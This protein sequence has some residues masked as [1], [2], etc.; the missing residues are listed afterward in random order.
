M[1]GEQE[2]TVLEVKPFGLHGM[3]YF[4]VTMRFPD[5][6][7]EQARLGPE[8]VLTISSPGERVLPRRDR[9]TM[10]GLSPWGCD[11]Q[12]HDAELLA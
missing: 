12:P 9:S 2:A 11:L 1:L 8:G 7:V 5:R 3:T 10:E 4:D 6:S